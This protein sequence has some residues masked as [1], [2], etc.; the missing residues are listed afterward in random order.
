MALRE[1]WAFLLDLTS[2]VQ[3]PGLRM[4]AD[5]LYNAVSVVITTKRTDSLVV[6]ARR[7]RLLNEA[8]LRLRARL[9]LA[10][11]SKRARSM[12]LS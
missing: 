12:G 11:P 1:L 10:Q 2:L 3:R 4:A 8:V 5:D 7:W 9:A 6:D